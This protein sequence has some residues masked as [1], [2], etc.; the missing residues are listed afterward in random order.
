[1][2]IEC[3]AEKLKNALSQAERITGKNLSLPI[4]SSIL[5]EVSGKSLKLRATNLSLGIEVEIPGKVASQGTVAVRGDILNN[6]F[7]NIDPNSTVTLETANDN[8]IV[9]T[10]HNKL[11]IKS[12]PHDD[13]PS[14][15]SASG[16]EFSIEA[17]K[18]IDG[19]KSVY[20]SAAVSDIKQE[21][22]SVYIYGETDQLLF[23][24]TDS[25]RLAEKKIKIKKVPEFEGLLIPFKNINEIIRTFSGYGGE[26][27]IIFNKNQISFFSESIYLTSRI[28]DGV[29]PDYKQILPKE[30]KTEVIVL[31]DDLLGALKMGTI[32]SD[33]FN[34]ITLSVKPK[35]KSVTLY[36]K[37]A[38]VGENTT[39]LEASVTG[40]GIEVNINQRYLLDCFQSIASDSII[41]SFNEPTRPLVVRGVSDQSFLYLIMPMNR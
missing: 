34:Q 35:E 16:T 39:A 3:S 8:L 36:S 21:I 9:E 33:K 19:L 17:G 14:L 31:R 15:P 7:S 32:F 20:Y 41:L 25:F 38:D 22:A 18:L 26:L 11:L 5:F 24:A 23:V 13:F 12:Y 4:L 29:F 40:A 10:K 30:F 27:K 37:N 6:I 1:M 28:I 2:K